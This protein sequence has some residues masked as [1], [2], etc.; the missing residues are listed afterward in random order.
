MMVTISCI[1]M[2]GSYFLEAC[3]CTFQMSDRKGVG[4][5]GSRVREEL[6]GVEGGATVIRMYCVPEESIFNKRENE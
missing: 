1:V 3:A 5:V 6:R 4:L 2:V